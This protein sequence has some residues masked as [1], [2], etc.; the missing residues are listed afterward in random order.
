VRKI[1]TTTSS[2]DVMNAKIAPAR[3]PGRMI[4]SVIRVNVRRGSAP[5][6]A[7][8][9]SRLRS[10]VRRL[11]ETLTT[12]N[13]RASAVWAS[14][15][16]RSEPLIR[17]RTYSENMP[18]AMITT[19]TIRGASTS[20][21]TTVCPGNRPRMSASEASVPSTVARIAV[22]MA[23]SALLTMAVDHWGSVSIRPYH[24]N[25]KPCGGKLRIRASVKLIG[26]ITSVGASR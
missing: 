14:T 24:W 21:F 10:I 15:S 13:G 6:F 22:R 7:A 18:I 3:T 1:A 17:H 25:E 8:A 26:T 5:R 19:G 12:T 16:P 11:A 9:S 4:G 23:T 20:P 2:Q